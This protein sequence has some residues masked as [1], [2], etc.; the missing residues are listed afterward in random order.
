MSCAY[1]VTEVQLAL[2]LYD[3]THTYNT[4]LLHATKFKS[5]L[6][7]KSLNSIGVLNARQ[8]TDFKQRR[9]TASNKTRK[10]FMRS[11]E[12]SSRKKRALERGWNKREGRLRR[13]F[14]RRSAYLGNR[15]YKLT[16]HIATNDGHI[17]GLDHAL[18][19]QKLGSLLAPRPS[20]HVEDDDHGE[21][22]E[23]EVISPA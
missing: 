9:L 21:R 10:E 17:L 14:D 6:T 7:G 8:I 13:D 16:T 2:L 1:C 20:P 15:M 4:A 18:S 22:E 3:R 11:P 23:Q 19:S 12:L 5:L